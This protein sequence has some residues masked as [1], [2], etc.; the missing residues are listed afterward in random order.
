MISIGINMSEAKRK[1]RAAILKYINKTGPC[2]RKDIAEY[3]GL[4]P[5][6]VT[7]LC[8]EL[9]EE[10]MIFETGERGESSGVG[11]K[12]I[13]LDL[14]WDYA[15]VLGVVIESETTV[16]ALCNARGRMVEMKKRKTDTSVSPE[17]YLTRVAKACKKMLDDHSDLMPRIRCVSVTVT[18]PVDKEKGTSVKAYDLWD[19]EVPVC[20]IIEKIVK[21]PVCIENNVDA[22]AMAENLFGYGR[23][24][25]DLML[26]KW[27]PGVGSSI[28]S[29]GYIYESKV[30]KAAEIGHIIVEKS[31][32]QC[33]CGKKGCLQTMVSYQALSQILDFEMED[34]GKVYF[35]SEGANKAVVDRAIDLFARTIVNCVAILA[36]DKV[37][38]L[39]VMAKDQVIRDKL[40]E[41]CKMYDPSFEE[42]MIVYTKLAKEADYIGPLASYVYKAVT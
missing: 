32:H 29:G 37:V 2:S 28:I 25:E 21:I 42:D 5:A 39:G 27:G 41:Y 19:E 33:S 11:R 1:N 23:Q 6:S 14:N 30:K 31:G 4:T 40:T 34:F 22:F 17:A 12:R 18:G 3:T 38:I 7:Q 9:L 20:S 8:Q 13:L 10:D 35:E 26:V 16:I 36:P 15:Y 24:Y